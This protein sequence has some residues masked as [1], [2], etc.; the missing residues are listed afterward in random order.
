MTLIV[1]GKVDHEAWKASEPLV[2]QLTNSKP[3]ANTL[4][5]AKLVPENTFEEESIDTPPKPSLTQSV[6]MKT[7]KGK[8][9]EDTSAR[10]TL[11]PKRPVRYRPG[12]VEYKEEV[13]KESSLRSSGRLGLRS[14][15]RKSEDRDNMEV[16]GRDTELVLTRHSARLRSKRTLYDDEDERENEEERELEREMKLEERE[17]DEFQEEEF[18]EKKE[19]EKEVHQQQLVE[20]KEE[21]KAATGIV[22]N[23][24]RR[25]AG[26]SLRSERNNNWQYFVV[27]SLEE[28]KKSV[29]EVKPKIVKNVKKETQTPVK[30]ELML[31]KDEMGSRQDSLVVDIVPMKQTSAMS[32]AEEAT[33]S[34]PITQESVPKGE[35]VSIERGSMQEE[36]QG[37]EGLMSDEVLPPAKQEHREFTSNISSV[38]PKMEEIAVLKEE[39]KSASGDTKENVLEHDEKNSEE[40]GRFRR[41]LRRSGR[42]PPNFYNESRDRSIEDN[43]NGV[44]TGEEKE[45]EYKRRLRNPGRHL[46]N[47]YTEPNDIEEEPLT[48]RSERPKRKTQADRLQIKLQMQD[49][50]IYQDLGEHEAHFEEDEVNGDIEGKTSNGHGVEHPKPVLDDF[51]AESSTKVRLVL[52]KGD[53]KVLPE[54]Q[55]AAKRYNTRSIRK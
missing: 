43:F 37:A 30:E 2:S 5:K 22:I 7:E 23:I 1:Q 19:D 50:M 31:V 21:D 53:D 46:A 34:L 47:L 11:R 36:M 3:E 18:E 27:D 45:G 13:P 32:A 51:E 52:P 20:K 15:I 44:G 4:K 9:E 17:Y 41:N 25:E 54:S 48:R 14:S 35:I 26:R 6:S 16:R 42:N 10:M 33:S 40:G 8:E 49:N 28:E 29:K 39:E 55:M 24:V 12:V 38:V